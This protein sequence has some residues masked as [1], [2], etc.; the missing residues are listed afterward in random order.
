LDV[1]AMSH[2]L[3]FREF[4]RNYHTTGAILPSGRQ[5]ARALAHYVAEPSANGRRILEVGPGTGAVTHRIIAAMRP[6]DTIDLVELNESFVRQL[7]ERFANDARFSPVASRSR[8]INSPVQDLPAAEPYDLIVSGLPLNNF[9][10]EL[11]ESILQKLLQLL[12]SGGTLS[13]F[14]YIAVRRARAIVSGRADRE[15]L[16]GIGRAM[17]A[18]LDTHEIRRDAIL[19]NI[20]PAWVHHVRV[21]K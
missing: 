16:R 11:V 8:I 6:N 20:P 21:K 9:S 17:R 15:R 19:L 13:F 14:E 3:F 18:V 10:A 2:R 4:I 7:E 1:L 5:L 12:K